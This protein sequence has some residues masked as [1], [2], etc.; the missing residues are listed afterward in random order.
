MPPP[1]GEETT[2]KEISSRLLKNVHLLRSPHPSSLRRTSKYVSLLSPTVG[3]IREPCIWTFLR[4][5]TKNT[6]SATC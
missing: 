2:Q 6:F 4:N 3:G 1:A 5:L